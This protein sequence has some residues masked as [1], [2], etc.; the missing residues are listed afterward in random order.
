MFLQKYGLIRDEAMWLLGYF[1]WHFRPHIF[2]L[3]RKSRNFAS[4]L[5][6]FNAMPAL[7]STHQ[8]TLLSLE[9]TALSVATHIEVF[10]KFG[11]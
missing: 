1:L 8:T 10:R 2:V 5:A 7:T 6:T 11:G 3:L 9:E 4:D